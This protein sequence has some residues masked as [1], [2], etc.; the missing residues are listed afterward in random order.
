MDKKFGHEK[1][2][3]VDRWPSVK[4]NVISYKYIY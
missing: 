1:K 3:V 4:I 2:A